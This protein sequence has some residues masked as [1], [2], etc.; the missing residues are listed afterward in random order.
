MSEERKIKNVAEYLKE[1]SKIKEGW[2]SPVLAFRGQED[3]EW[4]L[5]S[6]AERR[7]GASTTGQDKV[8]D[9]LFVEYHEDLLGRCKLKNY[10]KR[11]NSQLDELDLLADLQ[12]YGAATCLLDFTRNVLVALWFAC[13]KSSADGKVF[14]VNITDEKTFLE[15]APADIKD[16]SIKDILQFNTRRSSGDQT[17]KS[18]DEPSLWFWPPAHLNERITAQ[19]SL[20][21]FGLPSSI[22]SQL[23][24]EEIVIESS[25]KDW[26]RQELKELH[27][28]HEESLFPDFI[29]FAYTQRHNAPYDTPSA[30]EY[31]RRG[32][33]ALQ[34]GQ[35]SEAIE[36]CTEA[37]ER[38]PNYAAAYAYR[39]AS[40]SRLD[41]YEHTI[42]DLEKAVELV[43]GFYGWHYG[44]G[45]ARRTADSGLAVQDYTKALDIAR[46]MEPKP[47]DYTEIYC[48]RM[49]ALLALERWEEA[50]ADLTAVKGMG[51]SVNVENISDLERNL[52]VTFPEDIVAMLTEKPK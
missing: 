1:V 2:S 32:A 48:R 45:K 49:I 19:H 7:L 30:E 22:E 46:T 51:Q 15:I 41:D 23:R 28:I 39:G 29:G 27:D 42:Q 5:A 36:Y 47:Q 35:G 20:F 38:K 31:L 9:L 10:D 37:I 11:E 21:L 24:P 17:P 52:G 33:E 50:K 14:V 26:I 6:S 44:L 4:P 8:P 40:Y 16:K 3:A 18:Q 34:R 13:Q 12:H 25:S 43:P